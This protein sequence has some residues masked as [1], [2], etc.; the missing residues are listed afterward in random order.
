MTAEAPV[1]VAAAHGTSSPA[2]RSAIGGLVAAVAARRP[3]LTVRAAYVD[4][5]PPD[6]ATVLAS[7]TG[8]RRARLVPLLLSAGYH[9][10]VDLSEAAESVPGTTVA[11][12]L[13]PDDRLAEL[14][15]RRLVAAGL[16]DDD[17]VVLAAAGSSQSSAVDD[18]R[19][20]AT[21]LSRLVGRRVTAAFLSAAEPRL[22]DGRSSDLVP[23][24]RVVVATYLLAPGFFADLA[25]R[26][27]GD[28]VTPPLLVPDEPAPDELVDIV[29]QRFDG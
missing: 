17:V 14:L 3:D 29:L 16:R 15:H 11:P 26:A 8:G 20:V 9:V 2:R 21:A 1:L 25:A 27:G 4:V 5:Q 6:P 7:I 28:V 13:G 10:Y 23:G 19:V 24:R 18:C 12:A 22:A